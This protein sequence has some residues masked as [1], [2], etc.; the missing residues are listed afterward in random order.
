M[1]DHREKTRALISRFSQDTEKRSPWIGNLKLIMVQF[2]EVEIKE[3][4]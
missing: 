2:M 1:F 3:K 4:V